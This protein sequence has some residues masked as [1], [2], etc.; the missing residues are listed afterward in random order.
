MAEKEYTW[1]EWMPK[2]NADDFNTQPVESRTLTEMEVGTVIRSEFDT[3]EQEASCSLLLT[4]E[5]AKWFEAFEKVILKNGTKWFWFPCWFSGEVQFRKVRFKSRPKMAKI[6]GLHAQYSL[7]LQ[8][9][10]RELG[11]TD[12]VEL[13][14]EYTPTELRSMFDQLSLTLSM[15]LS[16]ATDLPESLPWR[17]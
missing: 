12:F 5:Q 1:P 4:P 6:N 13:L 8:V 2:P 16:G 3:D 9:A 15:S 14:L 7:T 10:N 17:N 11:R